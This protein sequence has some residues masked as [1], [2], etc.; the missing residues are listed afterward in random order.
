[1]FSDG[2]FLSTR[3]HVTTSQSAVG[4]CQASVGVFDCVCVCTCMRA[5][6]RACV[7]IHVRI[8]TDTCLLHISYKCTSLK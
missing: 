5:C 3:R 4:R 6:M 2:R 1:M 7:H 8:Y